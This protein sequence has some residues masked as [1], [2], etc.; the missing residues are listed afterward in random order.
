MAG[1]MRS[2]KSASAVAVVSAST[3]PGLQ[4]LDRSVEVVTPTRRAIWP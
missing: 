2:G 3:V 4:A 1:T